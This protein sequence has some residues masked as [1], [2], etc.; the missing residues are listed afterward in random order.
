MTQKYFHHTLDELKY[1]RNQFFYN[2]NTFKNKLSSLIFEEDS[3][4]PWIMMTR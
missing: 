4:Y 1:F 3:P 2:P